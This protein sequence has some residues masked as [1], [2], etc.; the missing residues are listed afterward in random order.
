MKVFTLILINLSFL[1]VS[2][3]E[4]VVK[5]KIS[6][7]EPEIDGQYDSAWYGKETYEFNRIGFDGT[8][9]LR[10]L[11]YEDSIYFLIQWKDVDANIQHKP[12][13]WDGK[14]KA[15]IVGPEREDMLVLRW[16]INVDNERIN[17]AN[18]LWMWGSVRTNQGYADDLYEIVSKKPL[19]R[20]VKQM[21]FKA[22]AYYMQ[23]QG[24]VGKPCWATMF[25]EPTFWA[26][27]DRYNNQVK[28]AGSR[29][30]V[31]AKAFWKKNEG[32]TI[33]IKRKLST[34]NF[35][36][37]EFQWGKTYLF[38]ICKELQVNAHI[39]R[40]INIGADEHAADERSPLTLQ[41]PMKIKVK[42][43]EPTD[44]KEAK[45]SNEKN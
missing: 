28:P 25:K 24:D 29:A 45:G 27:S 40:N 26:K 21:D 5:P 2:N 20:G 18:D 15:Y 31:K 32:W 10:S 9:L 44:Q 38:D 11:I 33:E 19:Q 8:L 6:K 4:V 23:S 1:L 14:K 30:D 12:W 37:V 22:A 7:S 13:R 16:G 17:S 42:Q 36:D 41:M 34:T 39:I 3:A 43:L 35:D